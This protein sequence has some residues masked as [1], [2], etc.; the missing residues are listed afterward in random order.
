MYEG[1]SPMTAEPY[2]KKRERN[3]PEGGKQDSSVS[4]TVN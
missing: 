4:A 3:R 2:L 1:N